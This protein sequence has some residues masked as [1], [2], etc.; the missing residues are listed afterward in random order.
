MGGKGVE[1]GKGTSRLRVGLW[2]IGTLTGKSIEL[3]NILHKRKINIT[4]V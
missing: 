2:N 1:R 3:A 4:Y